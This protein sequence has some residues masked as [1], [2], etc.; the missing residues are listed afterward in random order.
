[1]YCVGKVEVV[2]KRSAVYDGG[3]AIPIEEW[4]VAKAGPA[5]AVALLTLEI[6]HNT[7][8][9]LED[10]YQLDS[11]GVRGVAPELGRDEPLHAG[12]DGCIDDGCLCTN[13]LAGNSGDHGVLTFEGRHEGCLAVVCLVNFDVGWIR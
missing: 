6:V 11:F 8:L 1:M 13:G 7:L 9:A 3:D 2:D 5:E 4:P 10:R 12:L